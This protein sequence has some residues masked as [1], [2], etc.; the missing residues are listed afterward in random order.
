MAFSGSLG[1]GIKAGEAINPISCWTRFV[2]LQPKR[3]KHYIFGIFVVVA[4]ACGW[5]ALEYTANTPADD[6]WI[7]VLEYIRNSIYKNYI[8]CKKFNIEHMQYSWHPLRVM[9]MCLDMI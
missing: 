4:V 5:N 9:Q 3:T 7:V 1:N 6:V 8:I 2:F